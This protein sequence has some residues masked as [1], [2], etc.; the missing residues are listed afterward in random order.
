VKDLGKG[1]GE[2]LMVYL[3]HLR[4]EGVTKTQG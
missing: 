4:E 1:L 3:L 2:S